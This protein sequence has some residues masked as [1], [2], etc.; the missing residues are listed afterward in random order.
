M[1]NLG[2]QPG[3]SQETTQDEIC[4]AQLKITPEIAFRVTSWYGFRE[5]KAKKTCTLS[6][7]IFGDYVKKV[8]NPL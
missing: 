3:T 2:W 8:H 1:E 6:T 5:K 4:V 7:V